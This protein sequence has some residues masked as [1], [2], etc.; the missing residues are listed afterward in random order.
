MHRDK[1][2]ALI[3]GRELLVAVEKE[4]EDRYMG[5]QQNVDFCMAALAV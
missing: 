2:P 1:T 3:F 5:L 4:I